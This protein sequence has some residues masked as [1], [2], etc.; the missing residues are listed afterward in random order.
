MDGMATSAAATEARKDSVGPALRDKL[1]RL[2][3]RRGWARGAEGCEAS[4]MT[5]GSGVQYRE[6]REGPASEGSIV[7][8]PE[9]VEGEKIGL[10]VLESEVGRLEDWK[11]DVY[12]SRELA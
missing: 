10:V 5:V 9:K 6:F 12:R 11:V 1:R 4:V 2:I 7:S 3:L 8:R